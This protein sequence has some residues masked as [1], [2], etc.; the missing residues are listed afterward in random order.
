M[1]VL[2]ILLLAAPLLFGA[3]DPERDSGPLEIGVLDFPDLEDSKRE[4][5]RVPIKVHY[6]REAGRYPLVVFS[7]GGGGNREAHLYDAEYLASHGYVCLSL[8]HVS[9]LP[10]RP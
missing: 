5:R 10:V 6:P 1:A 8:E 4:G 2:L 7:H 3:Q 9:R